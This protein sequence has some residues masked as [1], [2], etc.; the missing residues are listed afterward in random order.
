MIRQNAPVETRIMTPDDARALGRRRCLAKNT[1]TRCALCRWAA[2]RIGQ[3]QRRADL[4]AG[5]V[6]RHPCA[7][8]WAISGVCAAGRQCVE[9]GCAP[10]RGADRA[11][12]AGLSARAGCALAQLAAELKAPAADVAD[13]VQALMDERKALANEVAQLRRELAMAGGGRRRRRA[14]EING[15]RVSCAGA[16]GRHGQGSARAD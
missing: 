4:F 12:G 7:P 10:D 11:G 14:E 13:R 16:V 2:G 3:G 15:D 1:A 6:R 8:D 5:A 9:R